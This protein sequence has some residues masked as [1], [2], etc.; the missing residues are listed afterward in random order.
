[1]SETMV[2]RL[3]GSTQVRCSVGRWGDPNCDRGAT[4][5]IED[6]GIH[7]VSFFYFCDECGAMQVEMVRDG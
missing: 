3:D 1:M 7:S 5:C 4:I 6:R 2:R